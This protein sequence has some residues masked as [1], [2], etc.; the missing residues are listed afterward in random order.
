MPLILVAPYKLKALVEAIGSTFGTSAYAV[1]DSGSK[2][3]G[4]TLYSPL[5]LQTST[6]G[7]GGA[8]ATIGKTTGKWYWEVTIQAANTNVMIGVGT[9]ATN[10]AT[11][12][13]TEAQGVFFY[14]SGGTNF[15]YAGGNG[16][17]IASQN[18]A[19]GTVIGCALDMNSLSIQFFINGV[20]FGT[21]ALV[22]SI[23]GTMI[24]PIVCD[25]TTAG[26]TV[27]AN[28]GATA[29]AYPVPSGYNAGVF[30]KRIFP[31]F[32]S[33][34]KKSGVV[35]SNSNLTVATISG[36]GARSTFGR[37]VGKWY[38]EV[39]YDSGI[40]QMIGVGTAASQLIAGSTFNHN[41][42]VFLYSPAADRNNYIFRAGSAIATSAALFGA[43]STIGVAVDLDAKTIKFYLNGT[44]HSQSTIPNTLSTDL[45]YPIV[46]DGDSGTSTTATINFGATT[47]AHTVPAGYNLGFYGYETFL[48]SSD[49]HADV[50]LGSDG[51]TA[52]TPG[53][54]KSWYRSIRANTPLPSTG[55]WVWEVTST[56]LSGG[57]TIYPIS[58]AQASSELDK[59]FGYDAINSFGFPILAGNSVATFTLL[60]DMDAKTMKAYRDGVLIGS[61]FA[62]TPT[63]TAA[64]NFPAGVYYPGASLYSADTFVFNFGASA[65]KYPG[66]IPANYSPL[67]L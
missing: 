14:T 61:T 58:I 54:P 67:I 15:I 12:S 40:H 46:S 5:N 29:F 27:L 20:F 39:K 36:G 23:A 31:T 26:A 45:I 25:G 6:T 30:E 51:L 19:A 16:R 48:S 41:Q 42:T 17:I 18:M 66:I 10:S 65:F 56:V 53:A 57:Q 11:N 64:T 38:W 24:Y 32:D 28:F 52:T 59:C 44:Y 7:T 49:K 37:T 8:R 55:K 33:A 13:Y 22:N 35:L 1:F 2:A 3:A 34:S 43:G 62:G 4:T 21:N 47:F 60:V 63:G 50:T 9:A